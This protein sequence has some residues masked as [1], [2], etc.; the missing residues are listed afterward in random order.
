MFAQ[1]QESVSGHPRLSVSAHPQG[2]LT[3]INVIFIT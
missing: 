2:C 3:L 1:L